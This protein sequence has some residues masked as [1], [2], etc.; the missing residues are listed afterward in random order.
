MMV[1]VVGLLINSAFLLRVKTTS[2]TLE[3]NRDFYQYVVFSAFMLLLFHP[4]QSLQ[5]QRCIYLKK[6]TFIQSACVIN[7]ILHK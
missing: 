4:S 6:R 3:E 1:N 5:T 2:L 7:I